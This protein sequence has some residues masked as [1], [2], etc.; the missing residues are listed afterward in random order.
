MT[1]ELPSRASQ[2]PVDCSCPCGHRIPLSDDAHQTRSRLHRRCRRSHHPIVHDRDSTFEASSPISRLSPDWTS[3]SACGFT[4]VY[5]FASG[6]QK[7]QGIFALGY[8]CPPSRRLPVLVGFFRD[9]RG[10]IRHNLRE[11]LEGQ[12]PVERDMRRP[13]ALAERPSTSDE[14]AAVNTTMVTTQVI[15]RDF[16]SARIS[17]TAS[18]LCEPCTQFMVFRW[19]RVSRSSDSDLSSPT[20][21]VRPSRASSWRL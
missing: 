19:S 14:R 15:P 7:T 5:P 6:G 2:S 11:N 20:S 1:G 16:G 9:S 17:V 21:S 13:P 18:I 4:E 10:R 12:G 8:P 3:V